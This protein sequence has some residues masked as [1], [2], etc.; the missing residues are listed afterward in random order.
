[1]Y[2]SKASSSF[3]WHRPI[4]TG[5]HNIEVGAWKFQD[6]QGNLMKYCFKI[7]TWISD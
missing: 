1:L 3:L 2:C 5:T 7:K 6:Y 4:V